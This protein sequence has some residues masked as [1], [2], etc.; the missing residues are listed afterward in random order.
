MADNPAVADDYPSA[1]VI[2]IDLSPIQPLWV[3]PNV[4]FIIDDVEDD[5]VANGAYDFIHMRHSC[6]YLKDVDRLLAQCYE[7]LRPGG[8]V[9]FSDFGGYALC[10]DGTM[11]DDY[12]LNE[13]FA[14]VRKAMA[15]YGTNYL[16]ANEHEEHFRKAGFK[17]VQC[18]V[19][20]TPIG[21]WPKDKTQRLIGMYFREAVQSLVDAM[22]SKPLRTIGMTDAE[23]E[24]FLSSVRK[25]L[26]DTSCHSYFNFISWWGQKV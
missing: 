9:E 20:K 10:D 1:E 12:P 25:S 11:P 21:T 6:A 13:C 17:N 14:L 8:W 18:R 23:L 4:R 5:W 15:K 22:G 16:I 2:G 3:P 19:V 7:N 24:V 26:G